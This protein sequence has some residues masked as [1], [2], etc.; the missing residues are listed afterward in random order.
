MHPSEI[1]VG[2]HVDYCEVERFQ[3]ARVGAARRTALVV[4]VKGSTVRVVT[5]G[6]KPALSRIT[7]DEV[8][9]LLREAR[10][11]EI[12][13]KI[14]DGGRFGYGRGGP[15]VGKALNKVREVIRGRKK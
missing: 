8:Y 15:A 10:L 7:T 13:Q 4:E 9:G 5:S 1:I 6:P 12:A 14:T 3:G 2:H 11:N